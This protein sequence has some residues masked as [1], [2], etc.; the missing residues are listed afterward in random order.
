MLIHFFY[1]HANLAAGAYLFLFSACFFMAERQ[2]N[3]GWLPFSF[4]FLLAFSLSRVEAPAIALLV[5]SI[6]WSRTSINDRTLIGW[7]IAFC[8]PLCL[9]QTIVWW[10]SGP[11]SIVLGPSMAAALVGLIAAF[12]PLLALASQPPFARIRNALPVLLIAGLCGAL[13]LALAMQPLS[14]HMSLLALQ[15]NIFDLAWGGLWPAITLLGLGTLLL[16]SVPSSRL[17]IASAAAYIL[18]IVLMGVFRIIPYQPTWQDS[19]NR[20]LIHVVP[21]LM[22]WLTLAYG[23]SFISV[24]TPSPTPVKPAS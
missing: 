15:S 13:G 8:A 14:V 19:G 1:L 5:I 16:R 2:S 20:M 17:F 10:M 4:A 3:V 21:L 11:A 18:L 24:P 22:F 9:W 23:R 12:V 7:L 6:A